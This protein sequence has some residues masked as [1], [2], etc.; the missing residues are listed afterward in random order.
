MQRL[1][2]LFAPRDMTQ[3]PPWKS[4]LGFALPMLI[5]NVAQQLYA[6]TDSV[7]VGRYVGDNALASV[8]SSGPILMFMIALFIGISTGA[9]ILVSQTYGARLLKCR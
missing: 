2:K 9:G 3:G 4:I 8:G 6:S 1:R 7:V 5:G